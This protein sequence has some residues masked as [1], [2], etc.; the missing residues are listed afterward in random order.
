MQT[1]T[2]VRILDHLRKQETATV[3]ELS[4]S[5]AMTGANIRHHLAILETNELI[6]L[7]GQRQ[8]GR[9]R[10]ENVFGLSK[11]VLGNGLPDLAKA[12]L[13][14]WVK[15]APEAS[16]ESGLKSLALQLVGQTPPAK[17]NLA[18]QRLTQLVERLN[19]LHY[20]A[21]WEAGNR[22]PNVILGQCPYAPIIESNPELCQ[23]DGLLLEQW[24]IFP[25]EQTAKLQTSDKGLPYCA[26]RITGNR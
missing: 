10:P 18:I 13:Q 23:M 19:E 4:R 11:R 15:N 3:R 16:L 20:Q 25:V 7:I 26:F 5:L 17:N 24:T 8:E 21:R 14:I 12:M 22:G 2:R 6:E 1:P 9:G